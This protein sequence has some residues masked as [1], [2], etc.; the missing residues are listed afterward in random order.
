[1][2]AHFIGIDIGTT[3]TKVVLLHEREG[4][5]AQASAESPIFSPGPAFAESD[6]R[7]WLQNAV[8]G[9]REV[10]ATSGVPAQSVRAIAT[11]GMVPAVV[12]LDGAGQ[13]IRRPI[14][15]NDARASEEIAELA[16]RLDDK[17]LLASTGSALTQQSVAPTALWL[18]RHEP[19]T[20][21]LTEHIVG[22]YDYVLIALG[23]RVHVEENW[24]IESGLY[25]L[26]GR[27]YSPSLDAAG[28]SPSLLPPAVRPGTP[29]GHVSSTVAAE[30]GL[31]TE[32]LLVVGGADHVLSAYAAGVD[33][34][35]DWLVKLGGAGDI[36][37]ASEMPV[38]DARL[39]LDA[40]PRPGVW[41]PNG[42][43]AT[44]GSLLRWY[45]QL[46][47][48]TSLA[49]LDAEAVEREPASV[50]CLPYFLG[51]KSPIH[52]PL[53]RGA[54][55]GLELGTDRADLYRSALEAIAFGFRHNAETMR[56]AGIRLDRALVTNG[57]SKSTLWKQIHADVL[58]VP[59]Y[60]VRDHPGASLGAAI[61]A[62]VGTELLGLS[63]ASR[64]LQLDA[65]F[66]PR[67]DTARKYDD[68]YAIWREAGRAVAP[69]SHRLTE[70][71]SAR[72]Q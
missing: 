58:N 4:I 65:P 57:G 31:T 3:G 47:G 39:Y 53:L 45:Q 69:I 30:T 66:V 68:A 23:A 15:Q 67:P 51:E 32:T 11:T 46:I 35:G 18:Q 42:C 1:V 10:L 17:D 6:S 27:V 14:L 44:S 70:L 25:H 49:E 28:I 29:V 34:P 64:F 62:G 9:I 40:H 63:D 37:S 50:I 56:D 21:A 24:A 48:G 52:D 71:Q 54:Y 55:L 19:E 33:S 5:V 59:L 36:L 26:D 60:P 12:C 38:T 16:E 72:Y 13:P 43:M 41:L 61:L 22:S 2:D 20:W 7:A 8:A